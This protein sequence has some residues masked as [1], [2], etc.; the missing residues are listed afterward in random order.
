MEKRVADFLDVLYM[1]VYVDDE[2]RSRTKNLI[3]RSFDEFNYYCWNPKTNKREVLSVKA[4]VRFEEVAPTLTDSEIDK[5]LK[6][7]N[8]G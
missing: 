8:S 5:V 1:F 2:G 4:V 7:E 3:L 6:K